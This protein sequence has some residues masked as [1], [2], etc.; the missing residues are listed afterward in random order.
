MITITRN[1][2]AEEP[3]LRRRNL[4]PLTM[5]EIETGGL[6]EGQELDFKREVKLDKVES[7]RR[8]ID[9]VVAFLNRGAARIIV[10][11]QEKDSGFGAFSPM[12][13]SADQDVLRF[14]STILE[15]IVPTPLDVLV[16]AIPVND[17]Y[18][19][20]IQIPHHP[21]GP[22]MN[23]M[24]GGYLIRVGAGNRP[25]DP[26]V[27]RSRFVDELTWMRTLDELTA[28][29]DAR[30]A[31][32]D[33]FVHARALRIA[34]L[35]REHFDHQHEPFAEDDY[36]RYAAP[37]F[38]EYV[39]PRFAICEDGHE[40]LSPSMDGK[41]IERLFIRDDWFIHAYAAKALNQKAGEGNLMRR[42]FEKEVKAYLEELADFLTKE[43]IEGPFAISFA[44]QSLSATEH[45]GAWFRTTSIVRTR[46]PRIVDSVD[47]PAVIG[48]FLKRV[49]QASVG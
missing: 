37:A 42:E 18:I 10:G 47:D 23:R 4:A 25:I 8:L 28:E 49:R 15:W 34:I 11:V 35:P 45:F 3:P 40:A 17:G 16:V 13:G 33:G 39:R 9:D 38:S 44:L 27:L 7:K 12:K 41:I 43:K 5:E 26:G 48:D 14:Q 21:S 46:R 2:P 29:E 6:K 36:V 1:E 19:L 31:G 24:S 20:D 22:F 30:I 32:N